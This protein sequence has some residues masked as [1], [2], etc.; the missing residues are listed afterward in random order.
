MLLVC[1]TVATFFFFGLMLAA[2]NRAL[3]LMME[4]RDGKFGQ[5]GTNCRRICTLLTPSEKKESLY[6]AA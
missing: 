4:K 6:C 2:A 3:A 5:S 1:P